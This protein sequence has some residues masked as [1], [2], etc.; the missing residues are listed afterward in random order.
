MTNIKTLDLSIPSQNMNTL[1][2]HVKATLTN[3]A[4]I[5]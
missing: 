3:H 1:D 5:P 2:K 4:L